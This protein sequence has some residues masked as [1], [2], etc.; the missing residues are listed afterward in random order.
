MKTYCFDIDGTICSQ[1]KPENYSKAVPNKDMIKKINELYDQKNKIY[2]HTGRHMQNEE[3][4]KKW[5]KK[6]KVKYHH[7]FFNK[8][9][10]DLYIDD[11]GITPEDFLKK[12]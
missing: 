12:Y 8:P 11:R 5:L 1:E 6:Y 10:G 7:I 2:L 4:T 3:I 9:V